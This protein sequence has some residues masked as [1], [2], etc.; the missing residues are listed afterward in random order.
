MITATE[1]LDRLKEG[2][3]RFVTG[4]LRARGATPS[5]RREELASGQ[6]PFAVILGC[7]DSRVPPELVFDQDLGDLFV[8]RVA[9]NLPGPHATGSIE[10]AAANLGTRLVVVLGHTSCGAVQT[11]LDLLER[12]AE[13]PTASL[14]SIV[15]SVAP[16]A[17]AS[18]GDQ[19]STDPGAVQEQ[20][21]RRN[22]EHSVERLRRESEL[23]A[24]TFLDPA[25]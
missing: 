8:I 5:R 21:I 19:A 17:S 16:A 14:R 10:F 18:L 11:T 13:A 1:A 4:S 23:L 9:G 20:A 2:N 25:G 3:R 24:G 12:K 6:S 7:S 22:I 15:D